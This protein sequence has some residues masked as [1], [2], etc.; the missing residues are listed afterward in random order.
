MV[1]EAYLPSNAYYPWTPDYILYSGV[2]ACWS[3]YSDL[4]FVYGFMRLI[5]SLGTMTTTIFS[6]MLWRSIG[7]DITWTC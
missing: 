6:Y 4:S 5:Y 3:E 2:H 7:V 1:G